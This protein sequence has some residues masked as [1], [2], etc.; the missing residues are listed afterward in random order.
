MNSLQEMFNQ[1]QATEKT[2]VEES[3]AGGYEPSEENPNILHPKAG[4]TY[5]VRL[6]YVPSEKRKVPTIDRFFHSIWDEKSKTLHEV[7]CLT[8]DYLM[9]ETRAAFT[10]CPNCVESSA[11]FKKWK[12]D[13]SK[14]AKDL[15]DEIKRGFIGHALIYVVNDPVTPENNGRV[16]ILEYKK[17]MRKFLKLEIN[18]IDVKT[19]EVVN[20]NPIGFKAF[21]IEN[22]RNLEITATADSFMLGE[23]QINYVKL[24]PKFSYDLTKLD[25][26][27]EEIEK[28]VAE[29]NFDKTY[30]KESTKEEMLA[31]L[32]NQVLKLDTVEDETVID[33]GVEEVTVE[34]VEKMG[35][36]VAEATVETPKEEKKEEAPA[37]ETPAVKP[38]EVDIK[39][40]LAKVNKD[41]NK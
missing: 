2:R 9:G 8:S 24:S 10:Q 29:L 15:Y 6:L 19:K 16:M 37:E 25:I 3:Q 41:F 33:D 36:S 26:T 22:G 38:G 14:S 34:E 39:S 30:Y 32:N 18:G 35:K 1:V 11:L 17:N 40:I 4:K 20:Q 23:K 28:K 12:A 13:G 7:T 31:F 21:D 27:Q 5:V